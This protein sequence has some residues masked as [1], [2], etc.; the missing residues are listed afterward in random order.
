MGNAPSL[1]H[2]SPPSALSGTQYLDS[3]GTSCKSEAPLRRVSLSLQAAISPHPASLHLFRPSVEV[4]DGVFNS[5]GSTLFS[6][7]HLLTSFYLLPALG[8]KLHPPGI[9]PFHLYV[10][11]RLSQSSSITLLLKSPG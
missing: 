11:L 10:K 5:L 6:L 7:S 1:Q 8:V 9:F 3:K 4:V 2:V